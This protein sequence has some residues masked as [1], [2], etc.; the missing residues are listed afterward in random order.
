MLSGRTDLDMLLVWIEVLSEGYNGSF[1]E[2]F[3]FNWKYLTIIFH[4]NYP[5]IFA[6]NS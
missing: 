4:L 1:K 6:I 5:A 2:K 3:T